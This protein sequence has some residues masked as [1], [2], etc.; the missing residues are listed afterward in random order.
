M[1]P[2]IRTKKRAISKEKIGNIKILEY[3]FESPLWHA[4]NYALVMFY[5]R[6][7]NF[8]DLMKIRVSDIENGRLNYGRSKTGN[9]FSIKIVDGLQK[10]LNYYLLSKRSNDYLFPTNYDGSTKHFQKYKSQRRR[11]NERL[12]IIAK[13]AGIEG[14]FTTYSIRHSWATIAKYMGIST[15]LISEA[16]GH[17]SVKVTEKYLRDFD[18]EVLDNV[19]L[20]VTG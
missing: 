20:L 1:P 16:F 4:K 15:E 9:K 14:T 8:I 13:D 5:S 10:I 17:S 6:G 2:T 18:N 12:R 19:N 7:M 3:P 11:M